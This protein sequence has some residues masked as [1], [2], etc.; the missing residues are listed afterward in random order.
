MLSFIAERAKEDAAAIVRP[1]GEQMSYATLAMASAAIT[2]AL[3]ERVGDP[4]RRIVG[5]AV[6]E[7]AAFV[8]SLLA[9]LEAGAVAMPLDLRRGIPAL[10]V[11]AARARALAVVV[12]DAATDRLEIVA[13]D[14]SRRELP[15]EACLL[16]DAGG[17]RAL[18]SRLALG[19]AV[20]AV[21]AALGLDARSRVPL[22][23]PPAHTTSL[24]NALATLRAGGALLV[25][26][27]AGANVTLPA[28]VDTAEALRLGVG[29]LELRGDEAHGPTMMLG[30][31]D[32]DQATRAAFVERDGKRWVRVHALDAVDADAL[33][34]V[35]AATP[36]V[37][38]AAV[39][40]VRDA[41]GERHYA[42]VAGDATAV[43]RHPARVVALDSLPHRS[44]GA[45]D[46]E[47]LRR[48]ATVE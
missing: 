14:A 29:E 39:L 12:G 13:V 6:D 48:M 21:A 1:G 43:P 42:F 45:V 16:V 5:I 34:R 11:E 33:E 31:L 23:D 25:G 32:D 37:R 28:V 46:R 2:Q 7:G 4:A 47:A 41:A 36:G 44:D 22:G 19:V 27:A 20:D 26:D 9:V 18:H 40:S 10:E 17:R 38:E 3:A 8:A 24:L 15:P 35:I 30:Y